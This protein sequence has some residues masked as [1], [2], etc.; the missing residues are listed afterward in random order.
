MSSAL[1]DVRPIFVIRNFSAII[2]THSQLIWDLAKRETGE[3]YAG[4]MLGGVWAI[5]HPLLM[6]GIYVFIFSFVFKVKIGGAGM[7]MPLDYTAYILAGL[8]PWLAFQDVLTKS[9]TVIVAN[10]NLV[11]QVVFPMEVLPIKSVLSSLLALAVSLSVLI[12]YVLIKSGGLPWTYLML[13]VIVGL[14]VFFMLGMAFLLSAAGAYFRDLKDIIQVLTVI[15]M[16]LMPIFYLP[17]WVPHLF[18]PVIYA[19]PFS[20]MIWCFQDTLYY[21]HFAH[22]WAW[23]MFALE[24]TL[25]FLIGFSLFRRL[26]TVFGNVL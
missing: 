4:Q 9:T 16:Y 6:M 22:P 8:V 12:G 3:R 1:G 5:L 15:N 26:K 25:F 18:K 13:P 23:L 7:Q 17:K 20:A 24:S 11:K 10:A 14:M 2:T 21:G 19:N